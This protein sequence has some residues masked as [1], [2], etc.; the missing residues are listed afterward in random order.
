MR[1]FVIVGMPAAGKNIARIY[2]ERKGFPYIATG[3]IVRAEAEKR[4]MNYDAKSMSQLS[5]EL[6]ESDGLGVTRRAIE[7]AFSV[8]SDI[9][10]LEGMRS[11]PEI[12]LIRGMVKCV[13]IAF[14]AP[15][16]LRLER[17]ISRGR[18]D[19][20]PDLFEARDLREIN[21]GS[22]VPIAL[23]DAYILNTD[24]IEHAIGELD[25][26][27]LTETGVL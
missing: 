21:Y 1:A 27:I 11:W 19:D 15:R 8:G 20:S 26:I 25:R 12:E 5:D 3:D 24:T 6:R 17:I 10:F 16:K 23:A 2:A 7:K 4:G 13:V 18:P 22:A 9:V 14:V